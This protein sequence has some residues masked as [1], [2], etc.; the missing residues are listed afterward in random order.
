MKYWKGLFII[1]VLAFLGAVFR[2]IT[3]ST[4]TLG[5]RG[6]VARVVPLEDTG[7]IY[8]F[9]LND[10]H[11][12]YINRGLEQ[13]L[14][15]EQLRLQLLEEEVRIDYANHWTPLDPFGCYKH[16][17]RVSLGEQ[18]LFDERADNA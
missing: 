16:I 11:K 6:E 4:P 1:V 3:S 10:E 18:V 14:T 7:D 12:Y 2:P 17:V 13:G 8:F 9:L 5:V 15:A